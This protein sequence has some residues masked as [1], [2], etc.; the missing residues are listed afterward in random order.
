MTMIRNKNN[1][2]PLFTIFLLV[3][4][5]F[6]FGANIISAQRG[7]LHDFTGSGRTSFVTIGESSTNGTYTW[8]IGAN[9]HTNLVPNGPSF[10]RQFDYGSIEL[11]DFIVADDFTGDAKTEP[12]VWRAEMGTFFVA[13]SP[14][15]TG[16]ITLERAVQWGGIY[17]DIPFGTGDYDGDGKA[18][19]TIVRQ[20]PGGDLIWFIMSSA[21]GTMRV[22]PFGSTINLIPLVEGGFTIFPG[23]DF[24]GDGRDELII[25][26][27]NANGTRNTYYIGDAVT[28]AGLITRDFGIT[29][30]DYSLPPDDYTG[31]GK[32]DFVAVR[33]Y[34][35]DP[36]T[37]N[38]QAIWYILDVAANKMTAAQ[39]GI[40]DNQIQ[41]NDLPVRGDYDGDK[42]HDVAVYRR[43]NQTFYWVNS[44]NG[45]IGQQKAPAQ[46]NDYPL[47]AFG[48]F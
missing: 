3:T 12:T 7:T 16:G 22:V 20:M 28:G 10:I 9:P 43:S 41:V 44:S 24:T 5:M 17:G 15:G 4:T 18:D 33:Q 29:N 21:T 19:F 30:S 14:T 23:A 38:S 39:F 46:P 27:R 45:S 31:D 37:N 25:I 8:R 36:A 1:P 2:R 32:A 34:D 47:G 35:S 42:R 6:S 40:A 26:A 13:Q 11:G 48:S